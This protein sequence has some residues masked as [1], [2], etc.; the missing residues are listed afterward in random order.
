MRQI[1]VNRASVQNIIPNT[2]R[3]ESRSAMIG[4]NPSA[5]ISLM[6]SISSMVLVVKVPMGVLSNWRRFR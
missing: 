5:K 2:Q 3:I 1:K 6:R 4:I